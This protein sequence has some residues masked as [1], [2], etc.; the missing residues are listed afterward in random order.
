MKKIIFIAF[1]ILG[2]FTNAQDFNT[3]P[4]VVNKSVIGTGDQVYNLG[5]LS[6]YYNDD[7]L[8]LKNNTQGTFTINAA[9]GETIDT[10]NT[11]D[12][13]TTNDF[14]GIIKD[15]NNAT[16]WVIVQDGRTPLIYE[17]VGGQ[18]YIDQAGNI[19]EYNGWGVLGAVDDTNNQDLGNVGA[20]N[21]SRLAGGITFPYEVELVEFKA[22]HQNNSADASKWGWVIF[23]QEKIED[24]NTVTTTYLLDE[25]SDRTIDGALLGNGIRDYDNNRNQKTE[26]DLSS[27]DI[28]IPSGTIINL[29]V[30]AADADTEADTNRYVRVMSGYLIF[31]KI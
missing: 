7:H 11:I 25:V 16:N 5:S 13:F 20:A 1:L 6:T 26:L 4:S 10:Q 18:Y 9:S 12:L 27:I 30:G 28:T 29:S 23:Y 19:G 24:S 14:I 21:T 22:W 2:I 8:V 17:K 31:S 3:F 15:P